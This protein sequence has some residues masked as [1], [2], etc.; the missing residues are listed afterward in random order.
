MKGDREKWPRSGASEYLAK[1]VNTN[2]CSPHFVCG[3]T[4]NLLCGLK[5]EELMSE[6]NKSTSDGGR[7]TAKLLSYEVIL[8]EL[9][10]T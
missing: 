6:N 2:N 10:L 4:D 7:S 8:D 1:P 5:D 9:G 3:F